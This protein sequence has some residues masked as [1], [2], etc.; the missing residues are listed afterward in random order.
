MEVTALAALVRA[1]G[2]DDPR[3]ALR[4]AAELRRGTERLEAELV[5]RA[6]NQGLSWAEVAAQLG[7]SKQAVHRKYG[8]GGLLGRGSRS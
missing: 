7:V 3:R 1:A 5:R 2:D 6:R 4:A 8:G